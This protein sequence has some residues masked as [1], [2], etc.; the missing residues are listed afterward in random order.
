MRVLITGG[1]GFI[2]Q[3][4][5]R[6]LVGRG[7][8]VV[9]LDNLLGQVHLDPA[10][11]V[12]AFPGSVTVG[13]VSEP[14]DWERL[15]RPEEFDC[16]V[17]LAA[18]TGTG[19]SMYEVDRY[20]KVNVGGTGLA[21]GFAALHAIP[22]VSLSSRAVYGEGRHA[23]TDHGVTFGERC[24]SRATPEPSI[25]SDDHRPVSVYGL[26]KS[27]GESALQSAAATIPVTTIRPQNVIG[28][29]QAL[30]NPYTGVLAAFLAMLKEGKPLTVYGAGTQTRD[31]IHVSDLVTIIAWAVAHP[32]DIGTHRV[33]NAGSGVRT[34]LVELAEHAMGGAPGTTHGVTHLDVHRAGDID[35]AC[36]DLTLLRDVGAPLPTWSTRDAV[37]D[38]IRASWQEDGA[39]ADAWDRA[40]GELEERGLT[41]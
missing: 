12:N 28:P 29:G 31:F 3:H 9:A 21:A 38:F 32:S 25:E 10:A 30:H 5:A 20:R 13:D 36:A 17:H 41:S 26:T 22:M 23:C 14:E 16:V 18:E 4:L 34:S 1:V 39:P 27:E 11:S 7:H 6:H 15:E 33:L 37:I 2:G 19:Q 40:L 24:C 35:D 8:E